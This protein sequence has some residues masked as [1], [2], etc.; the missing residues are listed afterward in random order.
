MQVQLICIDFI[1]LQGR[2]AVS[3]SPVGKPNAAVLFRCLLFYF[4]CIYYKYIL[5][6]PYLGIKTCSS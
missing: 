4:L 6:F 5:F 3:T 2:L 1:A